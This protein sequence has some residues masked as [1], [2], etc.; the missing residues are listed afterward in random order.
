MSSGPLTRLL[1]RM[2]RQTAASEVAPQVSRAV[3]ECQLEQLVHCAEQLGNL[4]DYQT[5]LNLYVEA[6]CESG[7]E[8]KLKNV[9][10]EL[11]RSGAPL[12]VC[13]LRRAALCDDVIQ[14]IKQRQ[15][16]IAS[17]IASGSTTAT[18]IGNTMIRTLF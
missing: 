14:T 5:L 13:G 11:S 9:I 18:S 1:K 3:K 4:H 7:S 15:P 8:R 6:L 16:A 17:R 2:R 12:Q 10:N